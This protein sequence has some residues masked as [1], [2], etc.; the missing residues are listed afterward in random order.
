MTQTRAASFAA[1]GAWSALQPIPDGPGH[2]IQWLAGEKPGENRK[3]SARGGEVGL[4]VTKSLNLVRAQSIHAAR[5][6]RADLGG[7]EG[8]DLRERQ[9]ANRA[10]GE[11]RGLR[12]REIAGVQAVERRH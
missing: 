11:A 5:R 12:R 6:E 3:K 9:T 10:N 7:R 4:I 2:W 1:Q 8:V